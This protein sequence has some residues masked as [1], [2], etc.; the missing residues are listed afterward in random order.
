MERDLDL[1]K[2]LKPISIPKKRTLMNKVV[3]VKDENEKGEKTKN[4]WVDGEVLKGKFC[5]H[6]WIF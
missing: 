3:V 2:I 1:Q 4:N 6:P 5:L